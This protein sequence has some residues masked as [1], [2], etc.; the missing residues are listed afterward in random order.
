MFWAT[1]SS[2]GSVYLLDCLRWVEGWVI[3]R[4]DGGVVVGVVVSSGSLLQ[5]LVFV[6]AFPSIF[7]PSPFPS[8][9]PSPR[10]LLST[11]PL[12]SLLPSSLG[13]LL[14]CC[15]GGGGRGIVVMVVLWWCSVCERLTAALLR[16]DIVGLLQESKRPLPRKLRKKSEKGFPGPL[17]PGVQK[18]SKKSR[19]W[20]F[21]KFFF[22]LSARFQ[23]FF[24]FFL[25]FFDPGAERPRE[26]LFR[27]FSEFSRERPSWLL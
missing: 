7:P 24:N 21:F 23:L 20:L 9:L 17:G 10:S 14:W 22:G 5:S 6:M 12:L 25:S 15:G 11:F 13:L 19:K 4:V 2:L 3:A 26:P 1:S 18:N 8:L 16:C 27:Y